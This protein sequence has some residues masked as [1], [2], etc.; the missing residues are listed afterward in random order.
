MRLANPY[1]RFLELASGTPPPEPLERDGRF[2]DE[3]LSGRGGFVA[4]ARALR[5]RLHSS[6]ENSATIRGDRDRDTVT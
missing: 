4:R 5:R 6:E 3:G 1:C 2:F